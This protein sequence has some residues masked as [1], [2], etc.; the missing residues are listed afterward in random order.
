MQSATEGQRRKPAFSPHGLLCRTPSC[1][2]TC[3][4]R[5]ISSIFDVFRDTYSLFAF[6]CAFSD[7]VV[8]DGDLSYSALPRLC[9]AS[10]AQFAGAKTAAIH[11]NAKPQN[12]C[13]NKVGCYADSVSCFLQYVFFTCSRN[14]RRIRSSSAPQE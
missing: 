4:V 9:P 3:T 14:R 10:K 2:D 5:A 1:I 12:Q 13:K 11:A 8:A 7:A 6:L